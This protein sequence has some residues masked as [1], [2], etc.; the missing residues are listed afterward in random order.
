MAS[1]G[2][3]QT[4]REKHSEAFKASHTFIKDYYY[5]MDKLRHYIARL[6]TDDAVL[7][8]NGHGVK[9]KQKIQDLFRHVPFAEHKILSL[10]AQPYMESSFQSPL[11]F[12]VQIAGKV[13]YKG[14]PW[15]A[16]QQSCMIVAD[17]AKYKIVWD[18]YRLV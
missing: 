10:D 3:D 4:L 11:S 5:H 16:F 14:K 8:W 1:A 15:T 18:C 17:C 9:G 6:Y 2:I 13:Q 7:I 12:M